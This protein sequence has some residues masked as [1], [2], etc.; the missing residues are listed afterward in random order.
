MTEELKL[1][2][3]TDGEK[4]YINAYDVIFNFEFCS[5]ALKT[6]L[7]FAKTE[8]YLSFNEETKQEFFRIGVILQCLVEYNKILEMDELEPVPETLH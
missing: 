1:P 4:T 3:E 6:L 7:N 2:V 8:A 5:D